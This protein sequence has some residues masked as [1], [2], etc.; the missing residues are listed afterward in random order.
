MRRRIETGV[1][2][3]P[4]IIGGRT[5]EDALDQEILLRPL[6]DIGRIG[7]DDEVASLLKRRGELA[8][9]VE[10]LEARWLGLQEELEALT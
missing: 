5:R 3:G 6:V 4:G 8:R 1:I 7:A 10:A 9:R 2:V